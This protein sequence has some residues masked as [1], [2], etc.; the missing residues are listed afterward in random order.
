MAGEI[1]DKTIII[2]Q[3]IVGSHAASESQ[4]GSR[5]PQDRLLSTALSSF[6]PSFR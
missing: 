6:F 4:Q 5:F 1:T 2:C 3:Q